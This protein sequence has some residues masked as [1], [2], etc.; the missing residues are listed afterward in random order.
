MR[1][2]YVRDAGFSR[3]TVAVRVLWRAARESQDDRHVL[4]KRT[5][6]LELVGGPLDGHTIK[7]PSG[8]FAWVAGTRGAWR[9]RFGLALTRFTVNTGGS[10]TAA[11]TT[12]RALYDLSTAG[13]GVAFYAGHRSNICPGCGAYHG[14]VEGGS[15]RPA[16]PLGGDLG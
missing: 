12:G 10:A 1:L 4:V 7:P 13:S 3:P 8:R 15:E 14:K 2:A 5:Q 6:P 16:C 11:P 9:E